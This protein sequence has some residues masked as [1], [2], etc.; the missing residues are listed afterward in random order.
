MENAYSDAVQGIIGL[1][2]VVSVWTR[3]TTPYGGYC[4]PGREIGDNDNNDDFS[5]RHLV[6]VLTPVL[7]HMYLRQ[8]IQY[9]K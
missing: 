2:L 4:W 3:Q 6:W 8:V 7:L 9:D 1:V 5:W